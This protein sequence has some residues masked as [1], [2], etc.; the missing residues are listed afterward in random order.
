MSRTVEVQLALLF[1]EEAASELLGQA[2]WSAITEVAQFYQPDGGQSSVLEFTRGAGLTWTG[3]IV[4]LAPR[5]RPHFLAPS[6]PVALSDGHTGPEPEQM[7]LGPDIDDLWRDLP[8][9]FGT[10]DHEVLGERVRELVSDTPIVV[11]TDQHITPPKEWRYVLWD[12]FLGGAVLSI[13]PMD[14]QYWGIAGPPRERVSTIKWRAR[15]ALLTIT[16][17]L[18]G[19]GRCSNPHCYMFANVDSVSRLDAMRLMGPEHPGLPLIGR[20][21]PA[22]ADPSE[23]EEPVDSIVDP[24]DDA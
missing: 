20:G 6:L 15:A 11:I 10:Y 24:D 22:S 5:F 21:F 1:K 7:I 9:R 19:I 13:A 23:V 16:G 14:P 4:S 8:L 18:F 17:E 3:A 12:Q 2:L